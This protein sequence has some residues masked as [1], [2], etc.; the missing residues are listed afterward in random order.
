[1][2]VYCVYLLCTVYINTHTCMYVV[3]KNMLFIY[4][5][6]LYNYKLCE[7][8]YILVNIFIMYTV[9]MFIYIYIIGLSIDTKYLIA[10]NRMIVMS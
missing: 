9:S 1:M 4:Y 5:I 10:I 8:K 7:Y 2:G 3:N 6:F